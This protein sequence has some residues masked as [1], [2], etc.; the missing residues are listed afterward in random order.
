MQRHHKHKNKLFKP[1]DWFCIIVGIIISIL[2][3]FLDHD[4]SLIYII[5]SLFM[6]NC[7]IIETILLI[8]G[9]RSNYIFSLLCALASIF[10]AFIDQFYG[11][12]AINV[13]YIF[14]SVIGFYLWDQHIDK[15]NT[16]IARKL[17]LKQTIALVLALIVL[18]IG[19]NFILK[20]FGGHSTVV[21]SISTLLIIV[22]SILGVLRYRE[23]WLTWIVADAL[24]LAMWVPTGGFTVISLRAFF[25][26]SSFY[27][28]YNWRKL[29]KNDNIKKRI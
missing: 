15:N 1:L 27:G 9:R 25:L 5:S 21:D 23:Q 28:Y 24:L 29:V 22:A 13:Y 2:T 8:K 6:L 19:L 10:V 26:L 16:V 11:N 18:S 20:L 7:G 4:H 12:M 17:T 3:V 14:I